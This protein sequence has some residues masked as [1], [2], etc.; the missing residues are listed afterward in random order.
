[1]A[2]EGLLRE[3]SLQDVF[4]LLELSKKTGVLT[5]RSEKIGDEAVVHFERGGIVYATRRRGKRKLGQQLLRAG[6][7]TEGELDRALEEQQERRRKLGEIL[8]EM[9]SVSEEELERQVR[10]LLEETVYDLMSWEEGNFRFEETDEVAQDQVPVRVKVESL[11]MEGARRIDEWTRLEDRIPSVESVPE[12]APV[13][14][15][16]TIL[17]LRP[18]EWEVLA[19]IDGARELRQIAADLGRSSFEVGKIIFGLVSVGVVRVEERPTLMR[20][21]DVRAAL[22][23]VERL[24]AAGELDAAARLAR[25]LEVANPSSPGLPLLN[26]RILLAQGRVRGATEAFARATV[27]DPQSEEA[28]YHLGFCAA[29]IGEL[30]RAAAAWEAYLALN[31]NGSRG[32]LVAEALA[33]ARVL[34]DLVG[35]EWAGG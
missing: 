33:A 31:P 10:F 25:E 13:E 29:R 22:D 20:E 11:L 4:Q 6:K 32:A 15:S 28:Q 26:G 14:D 5:V 12:L 27:L 21:R 8:L 34:D 24:L 9:G 19:E 3:L 23:E 16:A 1:M 35:R 17:D 2:L 18:D 30:A 7:L